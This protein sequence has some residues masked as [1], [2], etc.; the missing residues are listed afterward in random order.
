MLHFDVDQPWAFDAQ[1]LGSGR[2][3][4]EDD[5]AAE[6]HEVVGGL[7]LEGHSAAETQQALRPDE[8]SLAGSQSLLNDV[9]LGLDEH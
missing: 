6:P 3:T 5:Q 2:D 1:E 7:L 4:A 9:A 8:D